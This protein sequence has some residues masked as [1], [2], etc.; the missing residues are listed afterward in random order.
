MTTSRVAQFTWKIVA[1]A[2]A[3]AL[4]FVVFVLATGEAR[5][6]EQP[7]QTSQP[8]TAESVT[9]INGKV[10]EPVPSLTTPSAETVP[11]ET[12]LSVPSPADSNRGSAPKPPSALAPEP[13]PEPA[14]RPTPEP[15]TQPAVYVGTTEPAPSTGAA[16]AAPEAKDAT[17]TA[18]NEGDASPPVPELP[19]W[20]IVPE[21]ATHQ[22][23]GPMSTPSTAP[24]EEVP[25]SAGATPIATPMVP[26]PSPTVDV[27]Q[28]P[29]GPSPIVVPV[30]SPVPS[31]VTPNPSWG[32]GKAAASAMASVSST[33][34]EVFSI[35]SSGFVEPSA[36]RTQE[37]QS[38]RGAP[39]PVP[40]DPLTSPVGGGAGYFSST[41]TGAGGQL[42]GSGGGYA[43]LLLGILPLL[44]VIL[45]RRDV[46]TYLVSCE[47]PK[48]SSALLMPLERPG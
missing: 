29:S 6:A 42:A 15:A 17:T 14:T 46:R 5:A 44:A 43:P 26:P 47:M 35:L 22:G 19:V 27:T 12:A 16:T 32:I 40:L 1:L 41:P 25:A 37:E 10:A 13:T 9:I 4:C 48:P 34:T 28:K 8:G 11:V 7:S 30:P 39:Q 3:L 36:A 24:L 38:S 23:N 2:V 21:A 31:V 20:E 18:P 45:T 33:A